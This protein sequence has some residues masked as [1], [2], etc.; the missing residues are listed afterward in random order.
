M[1]FAQITRA[2]QSLEAQISIQQNYIAKCGAQ[3][4]ANPDKQWI[5]YKENAARY[6]AQWDMLKAKR[7][8]MKQS[9]N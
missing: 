8:K 6:L 3:N 4:D 7:D 1:N 9:A 2:M 5:E